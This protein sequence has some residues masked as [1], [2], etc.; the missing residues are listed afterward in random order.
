MFN[1]ASNVHFVFM[2]VVVGI[3]L[4]VILTILFFIFLSL[5]QDE[6]MLQLV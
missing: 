6:V 2:N 4:C 5:K 1:I 3:T